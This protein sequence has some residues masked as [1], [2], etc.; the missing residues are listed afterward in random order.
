[1]HDFVL[2]EYSDMSSS[3]FDTNDEFIDQQIIKLQKNK[4]SFLYVLS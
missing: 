4:R 3:L 1:M 2:A